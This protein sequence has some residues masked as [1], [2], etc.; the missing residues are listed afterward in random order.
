SEGYLKSKGIDFEIPKQLYNL[1]NDIGELENLYQQ[2]REKADE[3]A[4]L[5]NKIKEGK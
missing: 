4:A 3:L 2:N 5:L 1:K